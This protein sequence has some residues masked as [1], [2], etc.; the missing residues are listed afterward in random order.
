[1]GTTFYVIDD[2]VDTSFDLLLGWEFSRDT[3]ILQ[4]H[5]D[6]LPVPEDSQSQASMALNGTTLDPTDDPELAAAIRA[7]AANAAHTLSYEK[8]AR[9][10]HVAATVRLSGGPFEQNI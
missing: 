8:H 6:S 2:S 9:E 3:L 5:V 1:M 10:L 7:A 4:R